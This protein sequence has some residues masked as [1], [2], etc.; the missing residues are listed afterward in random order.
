MERDCRHEAGTGG[1]VSG[2]IDTAG[3]GV[4]QLGTWGRHA[5]VVTSISADAV[6]TITRRPEVCRTLQAALARQYCA[7]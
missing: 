1:E 2:T 5:F 6:N 4:A 3:R 7:W